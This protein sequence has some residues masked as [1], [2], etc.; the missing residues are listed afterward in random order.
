MFISEKSLHINKKNIKGM[1]ALQLAVQA[2]NF[3][4]AKILI[5]HAADP[6]IFNNVADMPLKMALEHKNINL[7]QL[8]RRIC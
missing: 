8:L 5:D 3:P 6:N 4:L 1:T 7:I 2:N